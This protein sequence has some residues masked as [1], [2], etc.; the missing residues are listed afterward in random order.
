MTDE[1]PSN[2]RTQKESSEKKDVVRV[3]RNKATLRKKSLRK[4]FSEAFTGDDN[5]GVMEYVIF[6]VLVPGVK[7][8][9]FDVSTM[10][11]E[12][13]LFGES[14]GRRRRSSG[15]GGGSYTNYNRMGDARPRNRRDRD[16]DDDRRGGR[17]ERSSRRSSDVP[18]IILETRVEAEET[19]DSLFEL[20]STY[21]V[22][23]MRDLLSL[24]GEPHNT[25]DED[26]GWTDLRGARVHKV[27]GGYLID[28]PRP[29]PLD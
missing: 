1:F 15:G 29:E 26:W 9:F 20:V 12:R 13:T 18:E 3:T 23:T 11:I 28:L 17:T 4:R 16:R 21:E 22:A 14:S 24:V 19:I 2:S 5:Q 7:D 10:A 6:D 25:T 27:R 8:V